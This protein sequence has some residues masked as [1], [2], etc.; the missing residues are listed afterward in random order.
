L[1]ATV[2]ANSKGV[3]TFSSTTGTTKQVTYTVGK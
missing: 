1:V 2:K 3:I